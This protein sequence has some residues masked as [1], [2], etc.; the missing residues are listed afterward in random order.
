MQNGQAM[1][2]ECTNLNFYPQ[3]EDKTSK[4]KKE[5]NPK[6]GSKK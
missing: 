5:I 1:N 4:S 6:P 3:F 2:S